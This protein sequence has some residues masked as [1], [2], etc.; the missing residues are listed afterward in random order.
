MQRRFISVAIVF[1]VISGQLYAA[2]V[3]G[4]ITTRK[5][6]S[7][8]DILVY[9][10][11][12]KGEF[13]APEEAAKMDQISLVFVP[14]LLPILKGTTVEFHN[15]D[16]LL[17]NVFGVGAEDFD[18][19]TWGKGKTAPYTFTRLG[20]TAILCNVHPEMEAYIFV[21]QNPYFSL[22]NEQGNYILKG[23]PI[24]SYK[25]KTYHPKLKPQEIPVEIESEGDSL[26]IDFE[27]K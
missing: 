23:L 13:P 16:D 22:T 10:Q 2:E 9:L 5:V 26:S 12:V 19:G 24:G 3:S 17:H 11:E 21:L 4:G 6:K 1:F 7:P 15:S 8:K 14:Y 27:L 18:L 20:E 25:L